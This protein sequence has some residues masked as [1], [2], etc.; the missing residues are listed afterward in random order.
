MKEMQNHIQQGEVSSRTNETQPNQGSTFSDCE[1]RVSVSSNQERKGLLFGEEVIRIDE[2]ERNHDLIK[3]KFLSSLGHWGSM[4]KVIAIHKRNWSSISAQARLQSFQIYHRALEG[5]A[6]VKYAWFGGSKERINVI[7]LHGFG[8]TEIQDDNGVFRLGIHL[9][10]SPI[11][12]MQSSAPDEDGLS[13]MLLCR[14]L[15][16]KM[17]VVHPNSDQ[18]YPTSK[19]FDSGVDNLE[20]PKKYIVWS[21]NMNTHILPEYVIS[22]R[23]PSSFKGLS[24]AKPPMRRPTSPWMSFSSLISVLSKFLPTHVIKL[25]SKY[26]K[27]YKEK[28]ISRRE[29]IQHLRRIAGDELLIAVIKSCTAKD[30]KASASYHADWG[31]NKCIEDQ[32]VI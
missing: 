18:S 24:R 12:C 1:S 9:P 14:V 19:E 30:L 3:N 22:F 20:S 21:T 25:I 6:N 31:T 29:L 5:N 8:H 28:K 17:K 13:H 15:L 23:A 4:T 16:G 26:F 32:R 7:L 27:D 10:L 11:D 2:E